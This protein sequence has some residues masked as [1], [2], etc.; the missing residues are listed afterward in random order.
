MELGISIFYFLV[1]VTCILIVF[2]CIVVFVIFRYIYNDMRK[3]Q[4]EIPTTVET[5][6]F[7]GKIP[8]N[9]YVKHPDHYTN[10]DIEC[11]D[12]IKESMCS[13]AYEGYLKGNVMKYLWRY[14]DKGGLEDLEKARVYLDWLI[15]EINDEDKKI[16]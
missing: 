10:G 4:D 1:L 14:K 12:A 7:N 16:D 8:I 9:G 2:D 5:I 13:I 11:I 3:D 6:E 15:D